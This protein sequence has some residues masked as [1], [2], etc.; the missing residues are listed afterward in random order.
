[1]RL[2]TFGQPQ[3]AGSRVGQNTSRMSQTPK[4]TAKAAVEQLAGQLDSRGLRAAQKAV[5]RIVNRAERIEVAQLLLKQAVSPGAANRSVRIAVASD[6]SFDNLS[7][8]LALRL[9]ERGLF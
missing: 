1:M 9:L 8:P 6:A 3:E 5:R 2:Q 4:S 7:D